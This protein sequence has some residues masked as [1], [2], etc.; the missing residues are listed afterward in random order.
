M[1]NTRYEIEKR[2]VNYERFANKNV[3]GKWK[4]KKSTLDE[5]ETE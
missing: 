2:Q 1:R 4:R 3:N 5:I